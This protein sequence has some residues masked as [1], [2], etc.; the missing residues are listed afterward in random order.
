MWVDCD[1]ATG[2]CTI[3]IQ[4]FFVTFVAPCSPAECLV[5]GY[6]MEE[7]EGIEQGTQLM[8]QPLIP[9]MGRA[10]GSAN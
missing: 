2:K 4:D 1:P 5:P 10:A 8:S 3:E 9:C 7:G 6:L